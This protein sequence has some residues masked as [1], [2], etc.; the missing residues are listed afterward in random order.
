[1]PWDPIAKAFVP[2]SALKE[3]NPQI[4]EAPV[5]ETKGEESPKVVRVGRP[6]IIIEDQEVME[7]LG[8]E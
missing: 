4:E 8:L 2:A 5:K 6:I 1:M 7:M 3:S